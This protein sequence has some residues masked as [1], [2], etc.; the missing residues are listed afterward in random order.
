[1][2]EISEGNTNN[3]LVHGFFTTLASVI[4]LVF[5]AQ[6]TVFLVIPA[7]IVLAIGISLFTASNGLQI[8]PSKSVYRKFGKIGYVQFG[9]WKPLIE[10]VK[11]YLK[12]HAENEHRGMAPLLG[13]AAALSTKTITYDI[14]IRDALGEQQIIYDFLDYN[15]AKQA[16]KAIGET[17]EIPVSNKVAEKLAENRSKRRRR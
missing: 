17:F 6:I 3:Y 13:K 15:Q 7:A 8:D 2:I 9:D 4:L 11:V 14:E 5:S 16:L 12:M 1:M 10:P